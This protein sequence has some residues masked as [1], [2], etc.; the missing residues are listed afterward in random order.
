MKIDL[1]IKKDGKVH[2]INL[3]FEILS[4]VAPS[5]LW[6]VADKGIDTKGVIQHHTFYLK[7][8]VVLMEVKT[9][10][11]GVEYH[12]KV[13][14][15]A[16]GEYGLMN[17]VVDLCEGEEPIEWEQIDNDFIGNTYF[18]DL[19]ELRRIKILSIISSVS[20]KHIILFS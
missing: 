9:V 16:N 1:T 7:K 11:N 8:V 17:L 13:V 6:I 18:V 10:Y 19:N 5:N 15:V 12:G 4:S 20:K 2:D 14:S 3:L